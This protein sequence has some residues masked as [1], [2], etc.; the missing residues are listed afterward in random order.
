MLQRPIEPSQYTSIRF[1][2]HLELEDIRPSI[3]S[4]G[5]AYDNALAESIIGLFK[6]EVVNRHGPFKTLAEVEYALMEWADWYNNARLH[7]PPR[8]PH[9]RRAGKRLLRSDTNHAD[10]RW[11]NTEAGPFPVTVQMTP[12]A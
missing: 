2:E 10:R 12:P 3:G 8:L 11:S 6:T 4:V 5:D 9:T 1:A 7:S